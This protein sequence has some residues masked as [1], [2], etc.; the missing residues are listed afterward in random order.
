[1][2]HLL[3]WFYEI[4]YNISIYV[5]TRTRLIKK[6]IDTQRTAVIHFVLFIASMQFRKN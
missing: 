2:L 5:I 4:A 1:M 3:G 6:G